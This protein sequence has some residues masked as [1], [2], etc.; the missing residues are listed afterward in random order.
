LR[1]ERFTMTSHAAQRAL[2][3]ALQIPMTGRLT[4]YSLSKPRNFSQS[5]TAASIASSSMRARFR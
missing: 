5:V 2:S 1:G 4:P 3:V